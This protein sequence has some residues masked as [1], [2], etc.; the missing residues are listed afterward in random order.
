MTLATEKK[1]QSNMDNESKGVTGERSL[2]L[3]NEGDDKIYNPGAQES[4][5]EAEETV[6]SEYRRYVLSQL[7]G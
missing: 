6:S 5:E 7:N 2:R 1:I 3:W 4:E